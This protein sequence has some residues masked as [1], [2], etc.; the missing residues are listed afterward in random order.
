VTDPTKTIVY[1]PSRDKPST[2]IELTCDHSPENIMEYLRMRRFKRFE[3]DHNHAEILCIYDKQGKYKPSCKQIFDINADGV[4]TLAPVDTEPIDGKFEYYYKNVREEKATY[5]T[6]RCGEY[7]I[8]A[9]RALGDFK[10]SS[11]GGVAIGSGSIIPA[12]G[13]NNTAIAIGNAASARAYFTNGGGVAIG[14]STYADANSVA[15]GTLSKAGLTAGGTNTSISIGYNAQTNSSGGDRGI[16]IGSNSSGGTANSDIIS[17]GTSVTQGNFSS[18]RNTFIG[19]Y[20]TGT[21]SQTDMIVLGGGTGTGVNAAQPTIISSFSVYLGNT[22]RSFFV[23]KNTN[24]VLKSLGTLAAGTDFEA[25]ATNTITIH[26]G[27]A[28]TVTL[29][30]GGQLY[31]EGGALKY[32]GTSGTISIIAPA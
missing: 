28:P 14:Q 21:I 15:I 3:E 30:N 32:R 27:T 17:I 19:Q 16:A 26:N 1:D 13:S 11:Q 7:T 8:S 6:D 24:M 4:V 25:A 12:A 9:T 22:Q 29:T 5:V 10:L 18:G 20:I 2:F 31:V 23:N